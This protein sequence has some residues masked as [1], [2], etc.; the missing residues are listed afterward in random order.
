MGFCKIAERGH[1]DTVKV[2][3]VISVFSMF[4]RPGSL[5]LS[6]LTHELW[7]HKK[8]TWTS[9]TCSHMQDARPHWPPRD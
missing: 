6:P 3:L 8:S 1:R 7:S 4:L 2:N 9:G 5:T